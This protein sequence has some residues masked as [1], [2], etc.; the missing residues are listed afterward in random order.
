MLSRPFGTGFFQSCADM[1]KRRNSRFFDSAS[2]KISGRCAQND[3]LTGAADSPP[4]LAKGGLE[5]AP[6]D[7]Y[8]LWIFTNY[9]IFTRAN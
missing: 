1:P 9:K 7:L 4:A 8:Q 2:A 3:N 6:S 5:R